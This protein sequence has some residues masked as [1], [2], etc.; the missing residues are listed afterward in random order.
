MAVRRLG[1]RS[2]HRPA[3]GTL[4]FGRGVKSDNS[5]AGFYRRKRGG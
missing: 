2:M 4:R 1:L 5:I 3:G